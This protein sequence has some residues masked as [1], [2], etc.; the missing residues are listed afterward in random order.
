[1]PN[2]LTTIP[3][4]STGSTRFPATSL[5][6]VYTWFSPGHDQAKPNSLLRSLNGYGGLFQRRL[7]GMSTLSDI[8][9]TDT[10]PQCFRS[11]LY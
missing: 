2:F 11:A 8:E 10:S 1:M 6:T 5:T 7:G 9:F 4:A 3:I